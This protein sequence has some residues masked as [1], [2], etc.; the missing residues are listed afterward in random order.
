V[1]VAV[2]GGADSTALLVALR[3]LAA[4]QRL[5]L[6]AAHLDHG[7]R[8][9]ESSRDHVFVRAL[10]RRL[11]VPLTSARWDTR[12]RMRSR[13]LSGEAG[14]RALRHEYLAAAAARTRCDNVVTA[15]HADDQLETVLQRLGRGTGLP[16]LAGMRPAR[17]GRAAGRPVRWLKPLLAVTRG[18][19]EADLSRV[20]QAWREDGSN[21]DRSLGRNR[22]RHDAVPALARALFP[23][24]PPARGRAL[25]A[26]RAAELAGD[27]LASGRALDAWAG[28]VLRRAER[29]QP[30]ET[31]LAV[32]VLAGL[33]PALRDAVLRRW[34]RRADPGGAGLTRPH[35]A[36]IA[37][38]IDSARGDGMMGLPDGWMAVRRGGVL[39]LR[40]RAG[41]EAAPSGLPRDG[42]APIRRVAAS[43]AARRPGASRAAAAMKTHEP[44]RRGRLPRGGRAA[45]GARAGDRR[46]PGGRPRP[47]GA[48]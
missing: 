30:G 45:D 46:H 23:T 29:I 42:R 48:R 31:G 12:A 1:L 37:G 36:G 24:L 21:T 13:G 28:R 39:G 33:R 20:R 22:L 43:A 7:L 47:S 17:A 10:C 44:I 19:I 15:H 14:L 35:L 18:E 3:N 5:E 16:G 26:R 6:H 8:G 41:T 27:A 32:A 38:L 40:P 4:E 34:W 11:D 2:S 25:L 9:R